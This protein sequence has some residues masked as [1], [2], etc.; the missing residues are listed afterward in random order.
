MT[1]LQHSIST[2]NFS[3][4]FK[5]VFGPVSR[6]LNSLARAHQAHMAYTSLSSMNDNELALHGM[7]REDINGVVQ[8]ILSS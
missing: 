3:S 2:A 5:N 1:A 4:P 8:R 7:K 6:F